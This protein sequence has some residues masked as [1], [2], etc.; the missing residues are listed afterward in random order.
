[1]GIIDFDVCY[2]IGHYSSVY[3]DNM[4][5]TKV[6]IDAENVSVSDFENKYRK[7]IKRFAKNHGLNM[8][9]VEFRAYAVE[10]AP[11]SGT[12]KSDGVDMKKIPGSPSSN[13]ADNQIVK[14]LIDQ[15]GKG[16]V[17]LLL[18]HDKGLQKRI[19]DSMDGVYVFDE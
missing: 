17:C 6:F 13:K 18:T 8:N 7:K 19:N 16:N 2:S 1:M 5:K 3:K 15:A 10:G 12:W 11:T 4:S 9:D 14:E